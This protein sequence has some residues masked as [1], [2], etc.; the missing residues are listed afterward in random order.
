M[1]ISNVYQVRNILVFYLLCNKY[2][3]FFIFVSMSKK[4][5]IKEFI[6]NG[7]KYFIP[8]LSIDC[9][10]FG[11]HENQLKVLLSCWKNVDGWCLPGGNIMHS[12][13]IDEAARRILYKRTGLESVFLQQFYTFGDSQRVWYLEEDYLLKSSWLYKYAKGSW[14]DKRTISIGYYAL[15]EYSKA[16]PKPDEFSVDCAWWDIEDLPVLLFDHSE[17]ISIALKTIR[18]QLKYKPI[19][20]NL[21]PEEFTLPELKK[22]YETILG[23]KLDRRNF[24]KKILSLGILKRLNI[25]RNIGPHRSPY[26]YA[27]DKAKYQQALSES[28]DQ[29]F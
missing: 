6:K 13:S 28:Y 12:E 24:Q 19:G 22:L 29:G 25:Q 15:I 21:L 17:M 4:A 8:Q 1:I 11:Y 23:N 7:D 3:I 27:F 26:L 2:A 14:I 9:V 16:I 20:I 5:D 18:N 10:I